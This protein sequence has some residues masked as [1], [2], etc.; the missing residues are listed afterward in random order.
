M[1]EDINFLHW[2]VQRLLHLH[3]YC[4]GDMAIIRLIQT[5]DFILSKQ[6]DKIDSGNIIIGYDDNPRSMLRIYA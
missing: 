2:L 1:D 6:I 5:I 3:Y 4:V